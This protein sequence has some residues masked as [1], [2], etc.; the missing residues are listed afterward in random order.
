MDKAAIIKELK[1]LA[2]TL[3]VELREVFLI[4]VDLQDLEEKVGLATQEEAVLILEQAKEIRETLRNSQTAIERQKRFGT[5]LIEEK[6]V[7]SQQVFKALVQQKSLDTSIGQMASDQ[8]MLS[9]SQIIEILNAH[10]GFSQLFGEIAIQF[11]YLTPEQV[12]ELSK[13]QMSQRPP[14][15]DILVQMG[16]LNQET[17]ESTLEKFFAKKEKQSMPLRRKHPSKGA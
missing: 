15:G 12:K 14:L 17:M 7:T 4:S 8:A 1:T 6:L 13:I 5:F 11:G 2:E 9:Y 16:V 3:P 10:P